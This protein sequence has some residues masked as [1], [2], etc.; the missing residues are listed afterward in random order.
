MNFDAFRLD[1][2]TQVAVSDLKHADGILVGDKQHGLRIAV[3][4]GGEPRDTVYDPFE[5]VVVF[6]GLAPTDL[7]WRIPPHRR[8]APVTP[9]NAALNP[10][11]NPKPAESDPTPSTK[12]TRGVHQVSYPSGESTE[13]PKGRC[14]VHIRAKIL[15]LGH[16]SGVGKDRVARFVANEWEAAGR[17]VI[18]QP[19]AQQVKQLAAE[20]Y[21]G[22]RNPRW[23]ENHRE[24]RVKTL[25]QFQATPIELWVRVGEAIRGFFG[26]TFWCHQ[27]LKTIPLEAKADPQALVIIPDLRTPVEADFFRGC[28]AFL[29]RVD[30]PGVDRTPGAI[31]DDK[32]DDF[33]D[34][35]WAIPNDG[36]IKDLA[37]TVRNAVQYTLL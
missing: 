34:W 17:R 25:P 32:L 2:A 35:D 3:F 18:I 30:R 6:H 13:K 26:E 11:Q 36:D 1:Q 4:L 7:L 15:C 29:W 9:L 22:L 16:R 21:P 12:S 33:H 14:S 27:V 37:R 23:Y 5:G 31:I 24:E 19:L 8:T 28:G 10:L 20:L